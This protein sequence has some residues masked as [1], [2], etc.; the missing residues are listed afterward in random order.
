MTTTKAKEHLRGIIPTTET[1]S[2]DWR[3]FRPNTNSPTQTTLH[4]QEHMSFYI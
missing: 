1:Q 4:K 2:S 3:G